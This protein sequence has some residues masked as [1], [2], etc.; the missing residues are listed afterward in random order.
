MADPAGLWKLEGFE[1]RLDLWIKTESPDPELVPRVLRWAISRMED[2][3]KGAKRVAGFDNL[4]GAYVPGTMDPDG[5]VVYCSYWIKAQEHT[6][7]CD[8]F[9]T[10]DEAPPL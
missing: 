1:E 7:T 6:V 9:G 5:S 3:H 10:H 8:L 4:W 2:P